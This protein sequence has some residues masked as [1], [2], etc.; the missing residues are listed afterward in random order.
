MA[1]NAP[2]RQ[3][4]SDREAISWWS[5]TDHV[6]IAR[7]QLG[8]V[9][10]AL[11]LG[12]QLAL[13]LRAELLSSGQSLV[14]SGALG[15]SLTSH[16]LAL[17]FLFALP[18]M[19]LVVGS[20]VLP[21]MV[22]ARDFA[23]P[24]L[25]RI[26]LQLYLA[27]WLLLALA[28][29]GGAT[30]TA[31]RLPPT[32]DDTSVW[33]VLCAAAGLHLLGLSLACSALNALVTILFERPAHLSLA[34]APVLVWGMLAGA[35]VQLLVSTAL[36]SLGIL[37]FLERATTATVFGGLAG[38]PF[39]FERLFDFILHAGVAVVV[40]PAIGV[41]FE[42]VATFSRKAPAGGI[43]NP[44][45]LGSLALLSLGGS[46]LSLLNDGASVALMVAASGI[47]LLALVPA[48]VLLY[49]LLATLFG[50]AVEVSV[51]LLHA[52]NFVIFITIG[53]LSG[54]FLATLST[55]AYL[56]GSLF[57]TAHL[58]FMLGGG[59]IAGLAT[60]L[61]YWWPRLM[62]RSTRE[63][64]GRLGAGLLFAGYLLAFLPDFVEG[65]R[66]LSTLAVFSDPALASLEPLKA[67]GTGILVLGV[68]VIGWDFFSS[69]LRDSRAPANPWGATTLDWLKDPET[70]DRGPENA[71]Q[72]Y[73]FSALRFDPEIESY[74]QVGATGES[75]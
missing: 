36:A 7:I 61:Y 38:D 20:L 8:G 9:V 37:L 51:P 28:M 50:G 15:G 55:G 18:A 39:A 49:N 41:A 46:G 31:W 71:I 24:A 48:T 52:L 22:G 59:A 53:G 57:D 44:L 35:A 2:A 12:I 23:F 33:P 42:V 4:T 32:L 69:L 63:L 3:I 27:S 26:T 21:S 66:G 6:R 72:A 58:H 29:L 11:V 54:L 14:D 25:N 70:I 56:Q 68:L 43:S 65:S 60:A 16:A 19:P 64:W 30:D 45:A 67:I 10:A 1:S 5:T 75:E 34:E 47:S 40:L 74:V 13:V 62:G 17:V 73:D